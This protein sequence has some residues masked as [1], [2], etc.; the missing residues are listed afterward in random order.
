[1]AVVPLLLARGVQN[2]GLEAMAMGLPVVA[3]P[4]AF[5]GTGAPEGEGIWVG[6]S[7]EDFAELVARL[8]LAPEWAAQLGR[9][10]RSFV[11]KNCVWENQLSR[12]EDLLLEAADSPPQLSRKTRRA[13]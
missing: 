4:M 8:L 11:E 5:Q 1:M 13:Q 3:T 12:L 6:K 7:P 10:A 9:R 2:K